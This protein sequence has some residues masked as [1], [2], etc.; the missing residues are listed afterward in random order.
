MRTHSLSSK[1]KSRNTILYN[2]IFPKRKLGVLLERKMF[3]PDCNAMLALAGRLLN[4]SPFFKERSF[5]EVFNKYYE[6]GLI[7]VISENLC[8]SFILSVAKVSIPLLIAVATRY[9]SKIWLDTISY[10]FISS[11]AIRC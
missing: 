8:K 1:L 2:N 10:F 9:A 7:V 11:K 4:S 5:L 3:F 6:K